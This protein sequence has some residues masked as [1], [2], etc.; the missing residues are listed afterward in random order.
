MLSQASDLASACG[1]SADEIVRAVGHCISEPDDLSA[2]LGVIHDLRLGPVV[3]ASR[4]VL[5]IVGVGIC[6]ALYWF[7]LRL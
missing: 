2:R 3:Q 5:W 7:S 4:C 1:C 6:C